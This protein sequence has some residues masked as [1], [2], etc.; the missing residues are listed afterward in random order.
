MKS[1]Q[2]PLL[3]VVPEALPPGVDVWHDEAVAMFQGGVDLRANALTLPAS[4]PVRGDLMEIA[5]DLL[6]R[7]RLRGI[8][9]T[10]RAS[11]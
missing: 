8:Y 5:E 4:S 11:A 9:A 10:S 1:N 7:A 3:A 2:P 6:R